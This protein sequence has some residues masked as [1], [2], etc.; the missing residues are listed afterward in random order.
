[1]VI[2]AIEKAMQYDGPFLIN[3]VVEAEE[4][5]YP[6]V[7]PGAALSNVLEEPSKEVETWPQQNT[8]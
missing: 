7:P 5:V 3:F 4:N 6:M 1:M 8:P 2:P